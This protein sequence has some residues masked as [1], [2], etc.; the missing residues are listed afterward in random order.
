MSWEYQGTLGR[1]PVRDQYSRHV[2]CLD[3]SETS[4]QVTWPIWTNERPAPE[5]HSLDLLASEAHL[6]IN[7]EKEP[8]RCQY[9][10]SG[11]VTTLDQTEASIQITNLK[12]FFFTCPGVPFQM[13]R[14]GL[15]TARCLTCK[16]NQSGISIQFTWLILTNQRPV[17]SCLTSKPSRP[18]V[19]WRNPS[20]A[21]TP[22]T[23]N[24]SQAGAE[25]MM[26]A[27]SLLEKFLET[28]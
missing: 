24:S 9:S 17:F 23:E 5:H 28:R 3:Q 13:T 14:E 4:I 7:A 22:L 20:L 1:G 10:Y 25:V 21:S 15:E 18:K 12:R 2:T 6:L 19:F 11:H 26:V 8:I 27:I 16:I